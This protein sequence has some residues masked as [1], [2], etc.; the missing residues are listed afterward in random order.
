M[1]QADFNNPILRTLHNVKG[2]DVWVEKKQDLVTV[3]LTD[4]VQTLVKRLSDNNILSAPVL[5]DNKAFV[6]F[7]DYLDVMRH[8]LDVVPSIKDIHRDE[9]ATMKV[10]GRSIALVEVKNV[11]NLSH[12]DAPVIISDQ[13]H[14]GTAAKFF[15]SGIHRVAI[16]SKEGELVGILSQSDL[17][18]VLDQALLKGDCK[19]I[20]LKTLSQLGF[21]HMQVEAIDADSSVLFVLSFMV[22]KDISAVPLI[23]KPTGDIVGNF[24]ASNL[25]GLYFE[26]FPAFLDSA[27]EFLGKFSPMSLGVVGTTLDSSLIDAVHLMVESKVHHLWLLDHFRVKGVLS[28]TDVMKISVSDLSNML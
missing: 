2:I 8:V 17:I 25:R 13:D 15:S 1:P 27:R 4:S 10:A 6:G 22:K 11:M 14:L 18:R 24:S 21:N 7:V 26:R 28:I 3:Q 23:D 20:G 5:D 12:N 19:V 9:L 16:L